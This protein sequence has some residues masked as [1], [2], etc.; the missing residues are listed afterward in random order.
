M[1]SGLRA[2][3]FGLAVRNACPGFRRRLG[4]ALAILD[5]RPQLAARSMP[6]WRN[7]Q[8]R[9]TQNPV[10]L[11]AS[12]GSIPSSGT[13]FLGNRRLSPVVESGDAAG[14][15]RLSLICPCLRGELAHCRSQVGFRDEV[16]PVKHAA[17]LVPVILIAVFSGMPARTRFR[18][19]VR[20][21][22]CSSFPGTPARSQAVL[23]QARSTRFS[24][25]SHRRPTTSIQRA[26]SAT[27]LGSPRA[28]AV[29]EVRRRRA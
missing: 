25:H 7:W 6:E 2:S 29:R 24:D 4:S 23:S 3:G 9:R 11:T 8:T 10:R 21:K 13:N 5:V 16:V 15:A 26:V 14:A 20:R 17:R 22:S 28:S 12:V 1:D 19:A 18:T 27:S